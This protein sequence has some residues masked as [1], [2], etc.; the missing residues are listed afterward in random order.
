MKNKALKAIAVSAAIIP[1]LLATSGSA[2]ADGNVTWSNKRTGKYIGT[3]ASGP[4]KGKVYNNLS[5]G[6]NSWYDQ[7]NSDGSYNQVSRY[8][9]GY[10]LTAYGSEVYTEKCNATPD[11]TN[12]YQRWYEV[13]TATGWKLQNKQS[14]AILDD[15]GNGTIYANGTDYGNSNLNQRWG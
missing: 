2:S 6:A 13:S 14:G 9:P 10:C 12:W 7:R 1:V 5:G 11:G 3:M 4:N 15:N 8:L